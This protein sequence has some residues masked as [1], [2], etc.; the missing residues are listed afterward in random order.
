MRES[1]F[2]D[3]FVDIIRLSCH[4][5]IYIGR[6]VFRAQEQVSDAAAD[7]KKRFLAFDFLGQKVYMFV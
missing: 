2:I 7:K 5:K 1:F 3:G 6:V 4:R